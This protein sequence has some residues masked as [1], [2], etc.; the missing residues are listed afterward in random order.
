MSILMSS[1]KL[2]AFLHSTDSRPLPKKRNLLNFQRIDEGNPTNC[3]PS[4]S[5]IYCHS[6]FMPSLGGCSIESRIYPKLL[7]QQHFTQLPALVS[8]RSFFSHC[9][10][11][12]LIVFNFYSPYFSPK[13]RVFYSLSTTLLFLYSVVTILGIFVSTIFYFLTIQL[14]RYLFVSFNEVHKI[15]HNLFA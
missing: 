10:T 15:S 12:L 4:H 9:K 7:S 6:L 8:Y 5:I 1:R 13:Q 11:F 14:I 3:E 2:I